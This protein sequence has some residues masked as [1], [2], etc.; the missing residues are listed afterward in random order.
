MVAQGKQWTSVDV[1][2]SRTCHLGISAVF[3]LNRSTWRISGST[4]CKN[5]FSYPAGGLPTRHRLLPPPR[6]PNI[7]GMHVQ[8]ALSDRHGPE[9]P[10]RPPISRTHGCRCRRLLH[11]PAASP[12][13]GHCTCLRLG[14]GIVLTNRYLLIARRVDGRMADETI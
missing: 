9:D 14:R 7:L 5:S 10:T 3:H 1:V 4:R 13:F 6:L 8:A 12:L 11:C 2:S